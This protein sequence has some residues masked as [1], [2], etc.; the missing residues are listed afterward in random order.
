MRPDPEQER[1]WRERIEA[2][3]EGAPEPDAEQLARS[4]QLARARNRHR[5]HVRHALGWL[6]AV[7]LLGGGAATAAW[8]NGAFTP[9]PPVERQPVDDGN[10]GESS[11]TRNTVQERSKSDPASSSR[12]DDGVIYQ[13][14]E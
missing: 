3:F 7:C 4:L 2:M 10:S 14:A 11:E 5:Q 13:R 1:A 9:G 12:R 6:V 8:W